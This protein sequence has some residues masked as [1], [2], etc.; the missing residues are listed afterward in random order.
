M[1]S[2]EQAPPEDALTS[3]SSTH[4]LPA[5]IGQVLVPGAGSA[6]SDEER[7]KWEVEK[8]KLYQQ[9]DDK[10]E[11]KC[12]YIHAYKSTKLVRCTQPTGLV[13]HLNIKNLYMG[14]PTIKHCK[15]LT[16]TFYIDNSI[17]QK[18][19]LKIY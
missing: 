11:Y 7:T 2:D 4:N 1:P 3:S 10:V 18:A 9:L 12:A 6:V 14:F 16:E 15:Q 19:Q 8:Q 5:T 17:E 13:R